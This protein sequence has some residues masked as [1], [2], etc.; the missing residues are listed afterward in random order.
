MMIR[1]NG[2]AHAAYSYQDRYTHHEVVAPRTVGPS[3]RTRSFQ[4][5]INH[6]TQLPK[7]VPPTN[8]TKQNAPNRI[9]NRGSALCVIPNTIEVKSENNS[10]APK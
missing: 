10:T 6:I 5:L 7:I 9:I 3:G 1:A 2:T 4:C 8:S